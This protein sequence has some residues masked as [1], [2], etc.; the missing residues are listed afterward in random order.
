MAL[1]PRVSVV[2][3]SFNHAKH[4]REAI[5]STLNQ[6]FPDFE[7]LIFDDGSTDDS[8][9]IIS[10]Y[11]DARIR[12]Y[13]NTT[14]LRN[15]EFARNRLLGESRG[16]YIAIHHSDDVWGPDKLERQVA[17]LDA[18]P[19]VGA[20]FSRA[21]IIN[22]DGQPFTDADHF[23]SQV[24]EQPNRTRHEWLNY[25]FYHVNAL[26]HPS[27]LIRRVCF[28][29]CGVYRLGMALLPD[30]DMWVRLCLK[31]E[32]H[33]LPDKLTYFRIRQNEVNASGSRPDTRV[34]GQFEF[35]QVLE[36]FAQIPSMAELVR[37]FPT[38][39]RYDLPA[40]HDLHFAL[41]MTALESKE[42]RPT[43]LFGLRL[44]FDALQDPARAE[45][46]RTLYNFGHSDLLAL[47]GRHDVFHV[48]VEEDLRRRLQVSAGVQQD[49]EEQIKVSAGVRQDLEG[50][51]KAQSEE[52]TVH[53]GIAQ[54][55]SRELS[56][57]KSAP[58]W[59]LFQFA[60]HARLFLLPAG[61]R[62]EAAARRTLRALRILPGAEKREP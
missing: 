3:T 15:G 20:V 41:G 43:G 51:I 30:F 2:L 39:E 54:T 24:F 4:L 40:G 8:W 26:C 12:A 7:L 59:R 18:N 32:I 31:Y 29:V 13:L 44:L 37:V 56:A 45:T 46:I 28:E 34:R 60:V 57:I 36:N 35:L 16:D 62:R 50:H 22:E 23:Y 52:I 25:F 53:S 5:D 11:S 27:V 42:H 14:T 33:V 49:L 55:R 9:A 10:T 1:N 19:Q 21:H 17:F 6:T 58:E 48:A 38:A 61:S 47:T